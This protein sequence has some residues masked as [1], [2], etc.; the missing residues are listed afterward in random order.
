M[1]SSAVD[2]DNETESDE[3]SS[4]D[5]NPLPSLH[6]FSVTSH[7]ESDNLSAS[8][9]GF[10]ANS[11]IHSQPGSESEELKSETPTLHTLKQNQPKTSASPAEVHPNVA[12]PSTP[13]RQISPQ[14]A[15]VIQCSSMQI[16]ISERLDTL[17]PGAAT[18]LTTFGNLPDL[19]TQEENKGFSSAEAEFQRP[20]AEETE[21]ETV[22][23]VGFDRTE[24]TDNELADVAG[25]EQISYS[26]GD[27][28]DLERF[29]TVPLKKVRGAKGTHMEEV[30]ELENIS[31]RTKE[32]EEE[33]SDGT[34]EFNT[35]PTTKELNVTI[36]DRIV[37]LS[38]YIQRE[39]DR[40]SQILTDDLL[41]DASRLAKRAKQAK[42]V[43]VVE[44]VDVEVTEQDSQSALKHILEEEKYFGEMDSPRSVRQSDQSDFHRSEVPAVEVELQ[45]T[46]GK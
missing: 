23:S 6:S 9:S 37:K 2:D 14:S 27:V 34:E 20:P 46:T 26:I 4:V 41:H 39:C 15:D 43:R 8:L 16:T 44:R 7:L 12:T 22:A 29:D 24:K 3:G 28:S 18:A 36:D 13:E 19:V 30:H 35:T 33:E 5:P 42:D 21:A 25:L 45:I 40:T 38:D 10:E 11:I 32:E 17:P 31:E 1:S